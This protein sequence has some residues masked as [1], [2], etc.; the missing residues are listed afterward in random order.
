MPEGIDHPNKGPRRVQSEENIVKDH[1]HVENARLTDGPWFVA[2]LGVEPAEYRYGSRIEN[3]NCEG[4]CD[5]EKA[6]VE[7]WTDIEGAGECG[8]Y[9]RRRYGAWIRSGREMEQGS[10]RIGDVN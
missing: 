6:V 4:V 9:R 8:V 2:P 5:I 3:G 1:E 10:W 7:F